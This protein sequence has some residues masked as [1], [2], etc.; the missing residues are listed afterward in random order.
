MKAR[1]VWMLAA[2]LAVGCTSAPS[3]TS[4]TTAAQTPSTATRTAGPSASASPTPTEAST[5]APSATPA[6]TP[7]VGPTV[8]PTR[9][10]ETAISDL[11][12]LLS[13]L[14]T[15]HPD[16]FH[17]IDREAWV[18]QLD[19]LKADLPTLSPVEAEVELMR[20]VGLLSA[21]GRDGH[22]FAL[23]LD[24]ATAL[25]IRLYEFDDGLFVTAAMAP[26]EDIAGRR[27]TAI[28][29]HPIADVLE[30]VEPLVP[31]DGPATV[32]G[33]RVVFLTRTSVLR[34]LG[35]IDDGPVPISLEGAGSAADDVVELE[36]VSFGTWVAWAE[37]GGPGLPLRDDTLYLS[38][39]DRELWWQ[40]LDDGMT[41]YIRY[42]QVVR[43][44]QA[45]AD[46]ITDAAAMPGITKVVL[47]LRQ[48]PGG[49]N[50]FF[51]VLLDELEKPEINVD[52]RL[53]VLTDRLTFSAASNF[54]TSIEQATEA[55]FAGE[56]MGGGLNFWNDVT[57]VQLHNYPVPMQ[58]GVSTRYWQFAEADD[59][60]L[61]IEPDIPVPVLSDDYF[62]GHDAVLEAVLAD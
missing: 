58:V 49:D 25:P 37:G 55:R 39:A 34:G 12:R 17:G 21:N 56:A 54:S 43:I 18:A 2:S 23:P 10:P 36:P 32:R 29:G 48:N 15:V 13:T 47:D 52:G 53:Y 62:S 46:A 45:D 44:A 42:P 22:Q 16:A 3:P 28:N 27:V 30:A 11:D 8:G 57:W 24:E 19:R 51:P 41:L 6:A 4:T 7:A 14:D 40:T 5:A 33:F 20:L 61:T 31:R 35:L 60:R 1:V 9:T 50:H 59:P 38:R 26:H